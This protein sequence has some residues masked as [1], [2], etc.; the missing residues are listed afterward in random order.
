MLIYVVAASR[1]LRK[2][3]S[4]SSACIHFFFVKF[5]DAEFGFPFFSF[6]IQ[7]DLTADVLGGNFVLINKSV[8]LFSQLDLEHIIFILRPV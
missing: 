2:L 8:L 4:L 1:T 3:Q 6:Q 7:N 5:A